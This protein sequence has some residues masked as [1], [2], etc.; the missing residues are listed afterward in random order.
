MERPATYTAT[1]TIDERGILTGW[2]D[3]ARRLLGYDSPAVVG[4]PAAALLP[5]VRRTADAISGEYS[6]RTPVKG[7]P[8]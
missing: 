3:G 1:A 4:R 8:A 5:L 2:S 7:T 6:G